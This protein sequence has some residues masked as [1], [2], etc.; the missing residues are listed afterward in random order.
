MKHADVARDAIALAVRLLA[1]YSPPPAVGHIARAYT[2]EVYELMPSPLNDPGYFLTRELRQDRMGVVSHA[3]PYAPYGEWLYLA[4]NLAEY[5]R[6]MA[7]ELSDSDN[8]HE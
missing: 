1:L 7:L 4:P 6:L 5:E 2:G 8:P 3:V